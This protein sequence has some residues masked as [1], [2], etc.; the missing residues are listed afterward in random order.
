[1]Y[2]RYNWTGKVML[3]SPAMLAGEVCFATTQEIPIYLAVGGISLFFNFEGVLF[4]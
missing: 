1:M 3:N 4:L 2:W